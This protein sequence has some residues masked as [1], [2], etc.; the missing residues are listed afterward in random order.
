MEQPTK[1]F[2]IEEATQLLSR[3][4]PLVEQLQGL[5]RSIITT[6]R[7]LDEAV[8]KL[9][10]GNGYPLREIRQQIQDLTKH[11]LHLI[12]A[13]QSAAQQLESIGC[14]LKD[15]NLGLVDFYSLRNGEPV[16]LC[17]KFGEE[18]IRFWHRL[19]DGVAGRQPL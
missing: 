8:L 15:L 9:S 10:Q 13:F 5:Q 18:Q 12:E 16:F 3:V 11:Q 2:N 4:R 19:E 17:W 6:N 1:M 7:Q 14:L